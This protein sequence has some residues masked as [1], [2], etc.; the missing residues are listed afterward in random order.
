MVTITDVSKH[1]GVSR[2]TVSRVVAGNGYVSESNRKAIEAAIAELGYRPNTLAQALRSN[3]SNLI[4]AVVVDV[5]TPYFAN[6]IY[7]VQRATRAAGKSLMVSS[8]YADQDEEA[9]A[10]IELVDRSCDGIVIYLERPMRDD[11]VEIVRKARVPVVSIGH[12]SCPVSRGRVILN[13]FNGAHA[14]MKHLLDQGH[15]KIVHLSGQVDF[16][17]TVAR[18]EGIAAALAE[19]GM[20]LDDIHVVN[21]IFHQD[22]GY[23]ATRDL[24]ASGRDFTAIFAGDDDMAAGVLLALR[25]MGLRVPDDVSVM[26]FDDAFHARHMWPPLTTVRQPVDT[27]GEVAASLL[28][29][30]LG[31]PGTG[32]LQSTVDTSLVVRSSVAAPRQQREVA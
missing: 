10:I 12:N 6:M 4:G 1:A 29:Q 18:M 11:V 9:R 21:G 22:F 15:R 5:G 20:S 17:D 8:G 19:Q 24:V 16:G 30:L 28:L 7:G 26:G 14:A 23:Q 3:R 32:P 25:D 31:E 27:L 13:N 2:S